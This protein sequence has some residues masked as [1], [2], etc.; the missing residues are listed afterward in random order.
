MTISKLLIFGD[1]WPFGAELRPS[2]RPYGELLGQKFNVPIMNWSQASTS[3][4]HM[5]L[6]LR[7]AVD[8]SNTQRRFDPSGS[9]AIFFLTSPDRDVMWDHRGDSK[10]LHLS[11]SHPSDVDIRWYSQFH[12]PELASFRVNSCLLAIQRFCE[13]HA[14]RDHYIWGWQRIDLWPEIHTTRFWRNGGSTVLDLFAENDPISFNGTL[15]DYSANK[16]NRFIYPNSG[17]PN[18]RGHQLIADELHKWLSACT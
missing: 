8:G 16:S 10:E 17:H 18:Q 5:L 13:L 9:D 12:T 7:M 6:Q 14:I 3:I 1:S 4:P 11:P 15:N 2:Q